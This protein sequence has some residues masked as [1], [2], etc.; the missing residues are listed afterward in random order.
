MSS[1]SSPSHYGED[2]FV[3][4]ADFKVEINQKMKVPQKISF[5]NDL[6]GDVRSSWVRDN[7]N[8]HVPERILVIGQD[9]HVGTRAPPREIA[10]DNSLLV[11]A[12]EPYPANLPRVATPPRT[13][14]LDKYPFPG[15]EDYQDGSEPEDQLP[16][17]K[18]KPKVQHNLNDSVYSMSGSFRDQTIP[19][20]GGGD[21][22]TP[23]EEVIHLR[24]QLA[25]L[26]RR[27]MVLELENVNRLQK[28]KI[29]AGLG[30]AYFLLKIMTW[31]NRG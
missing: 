2:A 5:G 6:N 7:F 18:P 9:Q 27:V 11:S 17:V 1:N 30:I 12:S 8:M 25:K 26:N 10:F 19:P 22:L 20:L 29:L 28:E 14:T 4:D 23:A 24:R 3:T 21:C 16:I 13:L 15:L 31:I